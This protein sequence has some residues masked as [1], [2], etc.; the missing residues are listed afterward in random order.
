M[1]AVLLEALALAALWAL[2][3][4]ALPRVAD[5]GW[6]SAAALP[7]GIAL[8]ACTVL[9]LLATRLPIAHPWIALGM[10]SLVA[11]ALGLRQGG[12]SA[13]A[14]LRSRAVA[15]TALVGLG[16]LA[17]TSALPIANLTSDSFR[18]ATVAR[19][20]V[21]DGD[22]STMSPFLLQTRLIGIGAVHGLA[23]AVPGYLRALTPLVGVSTVALLWLMVQRV[24]V[25]LDAVES[26]WVAWGAAALLA[27]N[28]RFIF[29]A[30][31]ING[32]LF[33]AVWALLIVAI[34]WSRLRGDEP[35]LGGAW[36]VGL[37][38]VA[39]TIV[40][41]EGF[42]VAAVLVAPTVL[43][44]AIPLAWRRTVLLVFGIGTVVWNL[45]V[46]V[47]AF[48]R[49]GDHVSVSVLGPI[50]LG[51]A[52]A[53]GAGLLSWLDRAAR[54]LLWSAH[55]ALWLLLAA[56]TVRTPEIVEVA[57]KSTARNVLWEGA[58]G[59]SLVVLT[60]LL[61]IAVG[62]RRVALERVWLFP[63]ASF[64]PISVLLAF[65]RGGAYRVGP[66]DS[67]N[68]MLLHV[69]PIAVLALAATA[70]GEPRSRIRALRARPA[71]HDG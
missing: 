31:Y 37:L 6:R 69:L 48:T 62:S 13:L 14:G 54:W 63:M 32:H 39:I 60:L 46:L 19:L 57:A 41:P 64:V 38:A 51:A 50:A 61:L 29:N 4:F 40:R 68:R 27:T 36:T 66:G 22:T 16:V 28:H 7:V 15:I 21:L 8:H 56:L 53:A 30:S 67:L 52:V 20:L 18:Y 5:E 71:S 2:G 34:C 55:A 49:L 11:V 12:T 3:W 17:L 23:A 43:A 58:W 70:A 47:P 9:V 35:V 65:F 33:F 42:L 44:P 10:A 59:V 1:T 24:T 26:R 45:G 25:D